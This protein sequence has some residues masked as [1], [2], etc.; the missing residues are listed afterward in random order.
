MQPQRLKYCSRCFGIYP[1]EK[2]P[3]IPK[4]V[5]F[6]MYLLSNMVILDFHVSFRGCIH[7]HSS[8]GAFARLRTKKPCNHTP[9]VISE[10]SWCYSVWF[11]LV[12]W[13][14]YSSGILSTT[15]KVVKNTFKYLAKVRKT[16]FQAHIC[17]F[18]TYMS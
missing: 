5:V 1:P 12:F 8:R 7:P 6:K 11:L 17:C 10:R 13:H 9:A 14:K 3:Q 16:V 4:M 15:Y 18:Q 2:L